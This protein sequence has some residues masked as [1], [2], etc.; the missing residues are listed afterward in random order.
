[1]DKIHEKILKTRLTRPIRLTIMILLVSSFFVISPILIAYSSGYRYDFVKHKIKQT[2]ILNVDVLPK[3]AQVFL[4]GAELAQK[5]PFNLSLYPD[6]YLLT[7]KKDGYKTWGKNISV[8]S[9]QTTYINYFSL[10]KDGLP[11]FTELSNV[12]DIIGSH[13]S[14]NILLLTLAPNDKYNI[15]YFDIKNN[16]TKTLEN[17][18]DIIDYS[19]S[20]FDNVV[21]IIKNENGQKKLVLYDLNKPENNQ[22]VDIDTSTN[23]VQWK[24]ENNKPLSTTKQNQIITI[25]KNGTTKNLTSTTTNKW[26]VEDNENVWFYDENTIFDNKITYHLQ[27]KISEIISLNKN[28]ILTKTLD[29]FLVYDLQTNLETKINGK[30]LFW[31]ETNQD[32]IVYSDWDITTIKEDGTINLQYRTGEKINT[33]QLLDEG[34]IYILQTENEIKAIDIDQY[35]QFPILKTT[36]NKIYINKK[37]RA[38][39]YTTGKEHKLYRLDL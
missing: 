8:N 27:N 37:Y 6:T 26:Y 12:Q 19:V 36:E 14:D 23:T 32:W 4:N 7:I 9:K 18:T 25:E 30:N 35:L 17:N 20:P 31:N 1:M 3:E 16:T 29:G 33:L 2:G 21:Y 34:R 24:N 5:I 39:F 13:N 15:I 38:L 10:L 28:R 11:M 22:A